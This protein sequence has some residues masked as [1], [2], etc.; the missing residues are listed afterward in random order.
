MFLLLKR[1]KYRVLTDFQYPAL[2]LSEFSVIPQKINTYLR[3]DSP[4][5]ANTRNIKGY[6]KILNINNLYLSDIPSHCKKHH[7][8]LRLSPFQ[9]PKS[10]IS[11]PDMGLIRLRNGHYQ[12]AR[13]IFSDYDTG[14]IKR[15]Y[16]QNMAL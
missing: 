9:G 14:Y 13:L 16:S 1:M 7:F 10:T 5:A 4:S 15:R 3:P 2:F 8:G 6:Y 11:H 12:K